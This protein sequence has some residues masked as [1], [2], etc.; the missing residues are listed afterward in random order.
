MAAGTG[1]ITGGGGAITMIVGMPFDLLNMITQQFRVTMAIIYHNRGNYQLDF[2]EFMAI[3]AASLQVEVGVAITKGMMERI[4]EKIM[5]RMGSK[6]A[7][8]LIPVVGGVIGG[9][10]NYLFIK[11]I[12]ES[13]KR[14][15][16]E[17][18][19]VTIPID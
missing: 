3:V 16:P 5:L 14:M 11:R 15:Q 4:A 8:R 6:T 2:A 1:V 13:I 7:A 10:A 18:L 19:P 12:G 17:Y 9:T